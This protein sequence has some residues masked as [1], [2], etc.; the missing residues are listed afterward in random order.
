MTKVGPGW[1][2]QFERIFTATQKSALLCS[3]SQLSF[4][5]TPLPVIGSVVADLGAYGGRVQTYGQ[6]LLLRETKNTRNAAKTTRKFPTTVVF[7]AVARLRP[8]KGVWLRQH[9][10]WC[11]PNKLTAI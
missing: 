5:T 10:G 6:A 7:A 11:G 8:I 9:F 4:Q 2:G 3:A 1:R